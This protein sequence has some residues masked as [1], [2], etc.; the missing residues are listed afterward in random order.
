MK[1]TTFKKVSKAFSLIGMNT[2]DRKKVTNN[3]DNYK[4]FLLTDRCCWYNS[5]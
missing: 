2:P 5:V 3:L 1:K 4:V